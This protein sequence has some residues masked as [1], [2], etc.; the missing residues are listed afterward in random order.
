MLE[1]HDFETRDKYR[2]DR[3]AYLADIKAAV[4]Q[5]IKSELTQVNNLTE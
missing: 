4:L 3:A 5:E 2:A 1:Q